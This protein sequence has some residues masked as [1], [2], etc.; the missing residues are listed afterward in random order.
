[1]LCLSAVFSAPILSAA[2]LTVSGIPPHM[3]S[4]SFQ[5]PPVQAT[6]A[7]EL[8]GN[9]D[10]SAALLQSTAEEEDVIDDVVSLDECGMA[11]TLLD[12]GLALDA[13]AT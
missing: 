12:G 3:L 6:A 2:C 8:S 7:K 13:M 4:S 5:N 11:N 9:S 10:E 1:M